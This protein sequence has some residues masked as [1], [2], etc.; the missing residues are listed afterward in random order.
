MIQCESVISGAAPAILTELNAR[1]T[2]TISEVRTL[3]QDLDGI[4]SADDASLPA[5]RHPTHGVNYPRCERSTTQP[6]QPNP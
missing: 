6:G 3:A 1:V 4:Q 5:R 2:A